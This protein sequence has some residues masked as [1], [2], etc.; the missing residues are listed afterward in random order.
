[1]QF[2]A[3]RPIL[4]SIGTVG[5]LTGVAYATSIIR[6]AVLAAL[7]GGSRALDIYFLALAPSQF[8]G[9]ELASLA[10]LTFLPEFSRSLREGDSLSVS[11]LFYQRVTLALKGSL[12]VALL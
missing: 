11:Q 9:L 4:S 7:Y 6:D 2:F 5:L 8:L 1:M 10:Y 12:G 3:R